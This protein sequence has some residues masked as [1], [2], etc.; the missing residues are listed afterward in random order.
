VAFIELYSQGYTM[1]DVAKK[2]NMKPMIVSKVLKEHNI[3][4]RP[5]LG[6]KKTINISIKG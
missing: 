3:K 1:V 6:R 2:Y 5:R 4:F